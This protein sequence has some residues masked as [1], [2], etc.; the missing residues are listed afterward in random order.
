MENKPA[1][2]PLPPMTT[3]ADDIRIVID[4][5]ESEAETHDQDGYRLTVALHAQLPGID[6]AQIPFHNG[7]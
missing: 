7:A 3:D 5:L 4:R 6:R 2:P 1:S